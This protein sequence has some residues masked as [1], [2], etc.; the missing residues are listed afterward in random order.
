MNPVR[1]VTSRMGRRLL[2]HLAKIPTAIMYS[3]TKIVY[4]PLNRGRRGA[5][6]ARHLFY[7]DYLNYISQFNWRDQHLIVFDHLVAPTAFYISRE[8]FEEW[9]RDIRAT[10]VVIGWHNKNSWRGFGKLP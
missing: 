6:L 8:E 1:R 5:K 7:N 2:Y 3:T 9:W 4:R 10:G